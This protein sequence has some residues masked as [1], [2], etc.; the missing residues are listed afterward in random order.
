MSGDAKKVPLPP[1]LEGADTATLIAAVRNP[2]PRT[3]TRKIQR[4]NIIGTYQPP[5]NSSRAVPGAVWGRPSTVPYDP[6]L[7]IELCKLVSA[8]AKLSDAIIELW[9]PE[10]NEGKKLTPRMVH[11]WTLL[12]PEFG[13]LYAAACDKRVPALENDLLEIADDADRDFRIAEN[14]KSVA[15]K[16]Q[17]LRSKLRIEAR[18]WIMSRRNPQQWGDKSTVDVSANI[19]LLSPEERVQKALALF[20][21]MEKFVERQ[22]K[23]LGGGP[24]VYDPGDDDLPL[25]EVP[26]QG[27]G[28]K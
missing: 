20:D 27:I 28:K 10:D 9:R 7:G 15:D 18:Q 2:K 21:L 25:L 17:L 4:K 16:E 12:N 5:N 19:M 13:A 11:G 14:G 6:E 8:G 26:R 23:P 1:E 22:T 24:L 3:R